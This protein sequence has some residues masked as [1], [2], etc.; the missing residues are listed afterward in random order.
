M[1]NPSGWKV[2]VMAFLQR[3]GEVMGGIVLGL[4]YFVL[5]GPVALL[6]R[7]LS[8]PL[9]TRPPA[10]TAFQPWAKE[11]ETVSAAQRQG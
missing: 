3:F 8:D 4:L 11:N 10:D 5:L 6:S 1:E 2:A 9:R 7:L